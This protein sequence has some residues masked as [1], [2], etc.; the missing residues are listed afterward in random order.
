MYYHKAMQY[1]K[2]ASVYDTLMSGVDYDSWAE[3]V[4]GFIPHG[5]SVLECACGTGKISL[6]LARMGYNVIATDISEDMLMVA[7]ESQRASCLAGKKLRFIRMDMRELTLNKKVDCVAACCDGVNYL[8]SEEDALSFFRSANRV[9]K[10]GG[11]LLFDISS[12]HKLENVLGN[13]CFTDSNAEAPYMWQNT[14]DERSRLVRMDLTFFKRRGELYERFD[15]THIQRAW[16]A[17]ELI[18]LMHNTGF[19]A[20]AYRCFTREPYGENDERI[21]F[22][23]VK[24]EDI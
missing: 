24:T 22:A 5:S 9:L 4:A 20:E 10:K 3:Y 19:E 21:Q 11:A 16:M 1:G 13:N 17:E 7:A 8:T 15:E 12:F 2:F 23:A 6:R 18:A 14:F